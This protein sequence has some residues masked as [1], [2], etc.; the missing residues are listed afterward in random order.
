MNT[1]IKA[2]ESIAHGS[3]RLFGRVATA[4]ELLGQ[5]T[6]PWVAVSILSLATSAPVRAAETVTYYYT[7]EQ[8]TP[9]VTADASGN[10]LST[11]DYR[12]F[13]GQAL[14]VATQGPGYT[15]HIN[16]VDSGFVYM[17]ARYYDPAIGRFLSADPVAGASGDLGGFSRFS[18]VSN[19]PVRNTDPDG[20]QCAQCLYYGTDIASI[21]KQAQLNAAASG[22]ALEFTAGL[23]PVVGSLQGIGIAIAEPT[24]ANI[25]IAAV[26]V[27]PE[28]GGVIGEAARGVSA[29]ER[30]TSIAGS[31]TERT[32]RSV[33]IAVTETSEGTRV[34]SSSE[35][36]LRTA[37]RDALTAGEVEGQGVARTHAEVN[38]I[39]AAKEMG[40]T[41]TGTAA[42][43]PICPTCAAVLQNEG[44]QPLSPLK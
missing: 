37:A 25:A 32:Q 11:A 36:K 24:A 44:V 40:L 20:K 12:P 1:F 33:T 7:N 18:Y 23:L 31:M 28:L 27:V 14:G 26:G 30:A 22:H 13:G 41:P 3:R 43:R 4:C 15:G 42:S 34:V 2:C 21:D 16:D 29:A 19:N 6:K 9:L 39:N 38:G 10:I 17:Q 8:G 5:V 35:G